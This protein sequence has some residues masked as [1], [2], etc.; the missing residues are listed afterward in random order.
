[1]T[2]TFQFLTSHASFNGKTISEADII[3][4]YSGLERK[5]RKKKKEKKK[6]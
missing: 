6:K 4:T 2:I 1:M 3:S 5:K